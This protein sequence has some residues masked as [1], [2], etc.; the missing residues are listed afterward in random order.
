MIPIDDS[1]CP[2]DTA[3]EELIGKYSAVTTEKYSRYITR[4]ADTYTHPRR[5]RESQ[6]GK[7]FADILRESLGL[8]IMMLGSGS[9]RMPQMGPIVTLKEL[10]QMFPFH[11]EIFRITLTGRQMKG[12]FDHIFRP[13]ALQSDHA[14]YYQYSKGMKIVVSLEEQRVKELT[15]EGKEIPDD[16]LFRI[17]IQGYHFKNM[18]DILGLTEESVTKNAPYK[19]VA[20]TVL[21]VLEEILCQMELLVCPEDERW[22]MLT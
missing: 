11:E 1:H 22:V 13:E 16:K 17:G 14:E 21:D 20:T 18:E 2:R 9:L 4:L 19:V 5:D 7:L 6:L 3:L 10:T 8:D 15:F 12:M